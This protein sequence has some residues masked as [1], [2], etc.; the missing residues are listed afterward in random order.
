MI[1]TMKNAKLDHVGETSTAKTDSPTPMK[2][3][4]TTAPPIEP[5]PARTMIVSS[6]EIRS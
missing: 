2:S 4:A 6:R 1:R 3:A 5:S